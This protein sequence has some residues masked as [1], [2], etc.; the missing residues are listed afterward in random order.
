M[1]DETSPWTATCV[2]DLEWS[3]LD[4][5]DAV[6]HFGHTSKLKYTHEGM[7]E[8]ITSTTVLASH[9]R[10]DVIDESRKRGVRELH[11]CL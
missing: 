7:Q 3:L 9:D 8:K 1:G 6:H 11:E 5:E 10:S 2:I 4:R